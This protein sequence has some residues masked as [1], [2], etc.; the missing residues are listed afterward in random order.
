MLF[1]AAELCALMGALMSVS[2]LLKHTH[3][4]L[5]IWLSSLHMRFPSNQKP[6]L[7]Y[8]VTFY[9]WWIFCP[10]RKKILYYMRINS[11]I[12]SEVILCVDLK[13]TL[14]F[15]HQSPSNN[16]LWFLFFSLYKVNPHFLESQLD[17]SETAENVLSHNWLHSKIKCGI[18]TFVVLWRTVMS[19][20]N[21]Q[22]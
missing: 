16:Y 3:K 1:L 21:L 22:I 8:F 4:Y 12:Q 15:S 19:Y 9:G 6:P 18:F 17:S 14:K 7:C 5:L 11:R 13:K 2:S 20:G 10:R